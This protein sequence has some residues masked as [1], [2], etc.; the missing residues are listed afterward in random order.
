[1]SLKDLDK[2]NQLA[3]QI[4]DVRDG[5]K[6]SK[7]VDVDKLTQ[8]LEEITNKYSDPDTKK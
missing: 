6:G 5:D 1:M 2:I 7:T 8:Q 4:E 3:K